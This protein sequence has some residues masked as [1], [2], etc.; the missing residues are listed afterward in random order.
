MLAV[1]Q[2]R[3]VPAPQWLII[4]ELT[5]LRFHASKLYFYLHSVHSSL[6]SCSNLGPRQGVVHRYVR[7]LADN[8]EAAVN[9]CGRVRDG[10]LYFGCAWP[11]D[12][13]GAVVNGVQQAAACRVHRSKVSL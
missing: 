11:C 6:A 3:R 4:A 9:G 2:F 10:G 7:L 13:Q 12:V 8:A 5:N 1:Q